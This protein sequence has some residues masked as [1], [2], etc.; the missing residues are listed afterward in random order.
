MS[1]QCDICVWTAGMRASEAANDLG[2]ETTDQGRIRVSPRLK[3]KKSVRIC[4]AGGKYGIG[5]GYRE[6]VDGGDRRTVES[7]RIRV[8]L[9]LRIAEDRKDFENGHLCDLWNDRNLF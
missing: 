4:I 6:T 1:Q 8:S 5:K 3:V 2:F 7:G 9:R